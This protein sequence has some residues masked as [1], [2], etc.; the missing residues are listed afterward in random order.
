MLLIHL[1]DIHFRKSEVGTAMDLN[2]HLRNE[3]LRDAEEMCTQ[4]G[5]TP[6]AILITGD[7]AYAGDPDEYIFALQW[8]KLLCERCG[9]ELKNIFVVPGNHD[10][11]R[12]VASRPVIQ[13]LHRDIRNTSDVSLDS[14]ISGLLKDS[15]SGRLLYESLGNY[16]NFSNQFFC[17]LLPPERTIAKRNL[18]LNDGSILC[19]SGLNSTFV[20]SESDDSTRELFVDPAAQQLTRARGVEN[21]VLCHHPYNWLRRGDRLRDHLN[22][23]ARIHLF[24]HEHT[25]RIELARDYMRISASA[26]HPSRTEPSW[27]PGY[28][29]IELEVL[30]NPTDR[31]LDVRAHVRVWQQRPGQFRAKMDK[32]N[33]TFHQVI[34]LDAWTMPIATAETDSATSLAPSTDKAEHGAAHEPP[35]TDPMDTLRDIS[36]RFFKL[37]LSKKSAIAG[38]LNLLEDE[39]MN[40]PDF[41]RFRRALIRARDRGQVEELDHEIKA[42]EE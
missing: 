4:V 12:E 38:K 35:R 29:L 27:E 14:I 13:S 3:L 9:A 23:V 31:K 8:L 25:N 36:V 17:G 1:S 11:V 24:G 7:L 32:E 19:L 33:E 15:E 34:N 5:S 37:S 2:A 21:I 18:I 39:D 41:E 42:I 6:D 26:A 28:N 40:Q 10:V 30:G 20:S 16:N 22:D